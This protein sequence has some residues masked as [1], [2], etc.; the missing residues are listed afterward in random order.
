MRFFFCT[1]GLLPGITLGIVMLF[2]NGCTLRSE[3]GRPMP[4]TSNTTDFIEYHGAIMPI[5]HAHTLSAPSLP[6][7]GKR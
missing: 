1:N 3:G 7:T 4:L 2:L 6:E 5:A